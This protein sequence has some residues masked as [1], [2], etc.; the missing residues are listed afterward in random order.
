MVG[1]HQLNEK[2]KDQDRDRQKLA[3]TG[4]IIR[5]WVLG[6][7]KEARPRAQGQEPKYPRDSMVPC[8]NTL[9]PPLTPERSQVLILPTHTS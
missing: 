7:A 2:Y 4:L 9:K 1:N 5:T 8:L 6:W 3:S